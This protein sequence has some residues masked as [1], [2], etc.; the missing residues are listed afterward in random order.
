M[1]IFLVMLKLRNRVEGEDREA[2][3]IAGERKH[4]VERNLGMADLGLNPFFL[5]TRS[6][7]RYLYL[8]R[9]SASLL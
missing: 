4:R 9:N 6:F 3:K 2:G 1:P 5:L 8:L 7:R